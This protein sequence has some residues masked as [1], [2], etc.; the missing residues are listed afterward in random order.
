MYIAPL[1]CYKQYSMYSTSTQTPYLPH[2]ER[3]RSARK[4]KTSNLR[5][6]VDDFRVS[7]TLQD[8][9]KSIAPV[10]NHRQQFYVDETATTF[11]GCY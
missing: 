7:A 8:L 1:H 3:L 2:S 5:T 6:D 11:G 4:V 10:D 9:L